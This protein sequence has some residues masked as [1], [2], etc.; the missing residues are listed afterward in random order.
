MNKHLYRIIFN[1][2]RGLLMV[3]AEIAKAHNGGGAREAVPNQRTCQRISRLSSLSFSLLLALGCVS[4][5]VQAGI[6]A[7]CSAP[8]NQ[9][10]TVIGS[11]NGTPQVNIQ[12]P[13]AGGVSHNKFSQFDVDNQGVILNNSHNNT[14]TQLG[15]MV[16]G[17]PWLAKK[18]ATVILN[19][20]NS[21]NPSQLNGY[22]EVAGKKAQV[23]IA[24]PSG[25]TCDGCGFINANR[26]TLTT[27]QTQL[28][29]GQITGYDIG[30]GNITVQGRGMDSS[31]QDSTD[32]IARAVNINAGIW[33]NDLKVTAGR[34]HVDA[35]HQSIRASAADGSA[36]P[37]LAID[38]SQLGGMYA[39]KIRLI[40]T[41]GGVGVRNAGNIGTSA[42]SVVVTAEGRIENSGTINS[43]QDLA[44]TAQGD[45]QN[46]GNVY[47]A[48]NATVAASGAL[49][50]SGIIAS[51]SQTRVSAASIN[52]SQQSVLAAGMNDQ[53]QFG[54]TGDLTLS[55]Q[56][57]LSARGQNLAPGQLNVQGAAVD[58]SDSQTS[59]QHI[60]VTASAGDLSTARASVSATQT[61]S[62]TT[63]GQLNN[64]GGK[65]AGDKLN[66]TARQ[67]VNRQGTVQQLGTSD[68]T[69]S[70]QASI[71]NS[72][73]T[74]ASNSVNL[75]F[76]TDIFD[77]TQGLI[78]HAGDG[79]LTLDAGQF[80]DAQ[81]TLTSNG[82]LNLRA[83]TLTLDNA[84]TQARQITVN[85]GTLS[86]RAG[87][88]AQ[89][90]HGA[91]TVTVTGALDNSGG[92]MASNGALAVQAAQVTNAQ[93]KLLAAADSS[94]SLTSNGGLNN[95]Q[96]QV[97]G[98]N[99]AVNTGTQAINNLQG[100][101]AA[102]SQLA[103]QS[104]SLN[105]DGGL[106][107]SGGA[108]SLN[109][110]GA[111]LS[112]RNSGDNGGIL[113]QG[114]LLI[115][116]GALDNSSGVLV[117][118]STS[119]LSTAAL[120]NQ[121]GQLISQGAL[122]LTSQALNNQAGL[123]QSGD[124]LALNTQGQTLTNTDSGDAGGI[125]SQGAM[126]L[127]TGN[128]NNQNGFI[129][130][131]AVTATLHADTLNNL[132][133]TFASR[134]ALTLDS[135]AINND[136]GLLQSAAALTIDTHGEAISNRNSG[137][138]GGILSQGTLTVRAGHLDNQSGV[139]MGNQNSALTL[140]QV[141]NQHGIL[142]SQQG[143]LS[144][145]TQALDNTAGLIQSGQSLTLDTQGQRLTNTASGETGGLFS[146][147]DLTLNAGDVDNQ[148]GVI[149][150]QQSANISTQTLNNQN[151][152][153]ASGGDLSLLTQAVNNTGGLMQSQ[154]AMSLDTHGQSLNNTYSG[155]SGGISSQGNLT[156]TTGQFDNTQGFIAS[157]A[158][159]A[160]TSG[161]FIN[162]NG[163]LGSRLDLTLST[164]A[165]T[166]QQGTLQAGQILALDTHGQ[167]LD[168]QNNGLISAGNT[169]QLLTGALL[170]QSG[171]L[172][173]RESL[174]INTQGQ[175]LDNQNGL[176]LSGDS[177]Q[178]DSGELN[179]SR[180]QL[181]A[182]GALTLNAWNATLTNLSGLIRSGASVVI[183]SVQLINRQTQGTDEGIEGQS[184]HI[185]AAAVDNNQGVMRSDDALVVTTG[186]LDN[187]GGLAS[188]GNRLNISGNGLALTNTGGTL[189]AGNAFDLIADSLTGDGNVLSQ[190]DMQ[191]ALN[192][193]F[194]NQGQVVANGDLTFTLNQQLTNNSLIKAGG[195]LDMHAS[196]LTNNAPAEISAG[197]THLSVDNDLTNR[198]LIDGGL[199]HI[200]AATLTNIGSGRIYG[201][202]IAIK[203]DTLN[204]LAESGTAA[205]IAAREQ[206]D[207]GAQTLNNLDHGLIYSADSLA[208][209]GALDDNLN[210]T[211]QAGILNNHSSTVES[212]GDMWLNIAQINNVND[213]LVT[214]TVITE[215]SAHH[216]AALS[217][218][219]NR[220]DWGDINTSTS[221]K[222]GVHK[223]I[224]PDGTSG[225]TFYEYQ[226]DRTVTETQVIENDPGQI[227]AGGNL[228]INSNTVNNL[229]SRIVAGGLLSGVIG[230]L[231][232]VA[233]QGEKITTDIGTQTRWY[234]KKTKHSFGG[235]TTSQGK[236]KSNYAP[237]AVIQTIDLKTLAYQGNTDVSGG[238]TT[239]AG[240]NTTALTG[241]IAG[242]GDTR[243]LSNI[244]A[245]TLRSQDSAGGLW[246]PGI[247]P[248]DTP[249][250]LPA[251]QTFHVD[252]PTVNGITPVIRMVSPNTR[253][254]DNSL[255]QLHPESTASYLVETDPRF[256]NQKKW[257]G[258]DYMQNA[259]TTNN[260]NVLKRLGD[261]YYEQQLIRQQI[262]SLT[263]QRYLDGYGNDEDQFKALMD[264]GIAF[265]QQ[266][267]LTLGV[268]LSPVQMALLTGDMV[269]LV[270]QT[271]TLPDGSTQQV[272]VPQLY[273]KVQQGDVDGSG[274]LLAGK[275]VALSVGHDLT[276]SGTIAGREVTQLT[277]DNLT[278]SGLISGDR[279]N[280]MARTDLTNLG[281]TLQAKDSLVA[282][283]GRDLTSSSTLRGTDANRYLDR[284]AGIYVQNDNGQLGLQAINNLNL[285]ATDISNAGKNSQT[286]LIAGNDINLNTLTT[287]HSEN[288][289]WGK[290]N[291]RSV[292]QS[293]DVGTQINGA[294]AIALQAGHDLN[295]RAATV[296]A[297]DALT[298]T[299]GHDINLTSGND[300]YHVTENSR[301]SSKGIV[302]GQ[303][304][305]TH[306]EV[307]SQSAI[308]SNFGGDKVTMQAGHDLLVQGSSVAGTHDVTLAAGNNLTVTTADETR[309]EN[310]QYQEKNTGLSGTGGIGFNY[311][312]QSLKTTDDGVTHYSAGSTVGSVNGNTTLSAG[313]NLTVKGS[314][315]LAAKDINLSGSE[316]NILAADN[317]SSQTHTV[318]QKQSG[319]TLALSGTVG[320]AIN[321]AVSGANDA[322]KQS[323]DRLAALDGMKAA[324]SGVQAYQGKSLAEADGSEGSMI[325]VN[326]SYGSQSSKSTQTQTNNQSQGST[327]TAG[328][329]LNIRATGTDINVQGSQLQA[330]KDIGL[331]ANRDVNL[332]SGVN[333]SVLDG[334]N[335][336]HGG[337]V[338][339][340]FNFGQ[341]ANGL[342]ISASANKGKGSET[343]N[344][345]SHTETTVNAGNNLNIVSGRDTTLTG[346][347]VS[348]EKVTMDVGRN[349]TLTSEQ[350]TD[351]YDSKQQNASAGGSISMGGG[352]ASMNLSKD[353]MHSTYESVQEQT[354]I[355]AGKGGFDITV[356]EHT[357]L[358][359]AVIGSTGDA[360]LNKLDTGTLGF[361]DIKNSAEYEVEHQSVGV[362][363]G[364]N[365]GGQFAGNMANGLLV[366]VNGSGSDSSTTKSAI[367]G[368]TIIVRDKDNQTQDVND[369]SRD[370]EHANQTLS[371]IFDKEKEQQRLQEAQKI[372]EIGSQA[373]DI[374]RTQ[375]DLNGLSEA[376]KTHP[377]MSADELRK[378]DVYKAEMAKYGTG[379]AIQQ[380]LQAATAAVQGLAGGDMAKAIAGGSAP[381][382]AEVI[383]NMTT[384][385]VTGKVNTE[386]N[387]MAH[388]V[389]G[390]VVAQINGNGALAGASGAA[391]GE[392]IAQQLYPNIKREDLTEEQ[393]QTISALGTMAAGLAGGL[394]GDSSA[395]AVAGAQAGKNALE[396]N[397]LLLPRPVPVP[398][399]GLPL[400]PGDKVVQ[401]ANN[402]M[403]SEL[404]KAL[405]GSGTEEDT[406]PITDGQSIVDGRDEAAKSRDPNV[407]KDLTDAEKAELGGTGSGTGTPPPPENDPKQQSEK[408]SENLN[409]KQESAIKK[410][411]NTIKNALKDHDITGT[412][413]DM[414]GNPVPKENGGYWDHM[415]EMQNTLRG[416]RNHA[417]TL[418]NVNNPE[419]QAAYGR[420]TDAIN[421]I[422]SALKGHGI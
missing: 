155:E 231:N 266:Y 273:A 173:S 419:A 171:Q 139:L 59:G 356:G 408:P 288:G 26:A 119:Q 354:G 149:V 13:G 248:L 82:A 325:G 141:N 236:D 12:T 179:N 196:Q 355:F 407:A 150:S 284:V 312:Q 70:H 228:A 184:V 165:L 244:D 71:D 246:Q 77:N 208:I 102:T 95:Q 194:V 242:A 201:D 262:I 376:K 400:S 260:D 160:I 307:Q 276:N 239:I 62:L 47:A 309:Q 375:G 378:T 186:S 75:T 146:L 360:S 27:G 4:L 98:G 162:Q 193:N 144:L 212:A 394:T 358:N 405:K 135:G 369:L 55:S 222:Y 377:E 292:T 118:G 269:W 112:N 318:E 106:L 313:N 105:N 143:N 172:Q 31:R 330:G 220:F 247:I 279:V 5:N 86:N 399:P 349:L 151:G 123:V 36:R 137:D 364:G 24:N 18:E 385:P 152:K 154:G 30:Q 189:I 206:L 320:S 34:N 328:N 327:V 345:T 126:T 267:H 159:A 314:D 316:V 382:L 263:G 226:Y 303:T 396:N 277:A 153:L 310:H 134:G 180:G 416:L 294:G 79:Q 29:N 290:G 51:A 17:N 393:R 341:G 319:L 337:S 240:R 417:D 181:Q 346:A 109:T 291:D 223:A 227:I 351:N 60:Q 282:I 410:I 286:T 296:N 229:D 268:A 127:T 58:L 388:A 403:A 210:A 250:V 221:N 177:L 92:S 278:N 161:E 370:V 285:T 67:L 372:G 63:P 256:T 339:V 300:S 336:S 147:G 65:L 21:R 333:T 140:A 74:I 176:M 49:T 249:L 111:A 413:K 122:T 331:I 88:L 117:G 383:H 254:P 234:A 213:H 271:V 257:L 145:T 16:T 224:M 35:D 418:K 397:S 420:A 168:N 252:L 84:S 202:H 404:D 166:N 225:N 188:S 61:L 335:E 274:A 43:A 64:T 94:F 192:Q 217:S 368:G 190:G 103:I 237:A 15:G 311:G 113:S 56:G 412:L 392:F 211:G 101:F 306:D 45:I 215:K 85:A 138:R 2:T 78:L 338:G 148:S 22:I 204:N 402:K 366:G 158:Q 23:V 96:G 323:S 76:N 264:N 129:L 91:M 218:S 97:A 322:S 183:N 219:P 9:Q 216:E 110:H 53:G 379:S 57:M 170:N 187:T 329:N 38:V 275:Q 52:A 302:S 371:P 305:T 344:G 169:L 238:G 350:D 409:Q 363:T 359:G 343:G 301:Q 295:A 298:A 89:S 32:L 380:G 255:F 422:E 116:S 280:L 411:D 3:V 7:D 391:V 174:S 352:S 214:A 136:G 258:S 83:N 28:N 40:G 398:V 272:L 6:V 270:A 121:Q 395:D 232:N 182:V 108:L 401:D 124:T 20:V 132:S 39:G 93:G 142:G 87:S 19:E 347:Q 120:N 69:L 81:G 251:G 131:Q 317:Q 324:L 66:L 265:G 10:P 104:G 209:G 37:A 321:T 68:L 332:W 100:V 99:L 195:V 25:I 1:K 11:A 361:S 107:Q 200:D 353:K 133:G 326:L 384:D 114:N 197:A 374:A 80:N 357:Q 130:G 340:G 235:T 289:S 293:T 362:S 73:G 406:P 207:I 178:I 283:A 156:L 386:A 241:D 390:A 167:Q 128:L 315:V 414:D 308:G 50:H 164:A 163:L 299:A 334:S 365:I 415:Q 261:G 373:M 381:Y 48:G 259:F 42:G 54:S 33:A 175:L 90:G 46:S 41:Q 342:S 205:T 14:S 157:N 203:S 297:A 191:L 72:G 304:I 389:V 387:L 230:Y 199:T 245:A 185:S 44:V 8:G 243:G 233:T 253:L 281:G 367:S 198:G 115:S 125:L 287:T 421:K 348:G